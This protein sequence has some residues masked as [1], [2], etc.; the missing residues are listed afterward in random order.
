MKIKNLFALTICVLI[1]TACTPAPATEITNQP[2]T[3]P[4][5][6]TATS[7]PN[8][9]PVATASASSIVS[10]KGTLSGKLCYPSSFLPEG[11]IEAKNTQ[12]NESV[13]LPYPGSANGGKSS[14]EL[15]VPPGSYKVRFSVMMPNN[16]EPMPGYHTACTGVEKICQD[17][18]TTREA[19]TVSVKA[20]QTTTGVDLCD[21]YYKIENEPKF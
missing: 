14:Y 18:N 8:P 10:A 4:T 19:L 15:Q 9:T 13:F 6:I 1:L 17:Q 5:E 3:A 16:P 21:F 7:T 12:T 20:G 2:T 11:K